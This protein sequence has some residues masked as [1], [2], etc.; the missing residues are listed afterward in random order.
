M[1]WTRTLDYDPV[2]KTATKMHYDAA[3]DIITTYDEQDVAQIAAD[4]KALRNDQPSWRKWKGDWHHIGV[5]PNNVYW[6]LWKEGRL[7]SQDMNAF[8]KWWNEN[9][10]TWATKTGRL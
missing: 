7:P 2:T 8:R 10:D 5:I 9:Q 6:M 1:S 3:G 4:A